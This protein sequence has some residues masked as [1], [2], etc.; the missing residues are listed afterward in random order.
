MP[1]Q[2]EIIAFNDKFNSLNI[3]NSDS[4]I[5]IITYGLIVDFDGDFPISFESFK[6]AYFSEGINFISRLNGSWLIYIHDKFN[7]VKYV[8]TDQYSDQSIY[9]SHSE[10]GLY[11]SNSIWNVLEKTDGSN[12]HLSELG[13]NQMLNFGQCFKDFTLFKN[14]KKLIAGHFIEID[15]NHEFSTKKYHQFIVHDIEIDKDSILKKLDAL[16]NQ[17]V[18]RQFKID[19]YLGFSRSTCFLSGGMDSRNTVLTAKR[20]GFNIKALSFGSAD[21][22]DLAIASEICKHNGI[23]HQIRHFDFSK[24][25]DSFIA[26]IKSSDGLTS[27]E[28]VLDTFHNGKSIDLNYIGVLHT[29]QIG[30]IIGSRPPIFQRSQNLISEL[31]VSFNNKNEF[32]ETIYEKSFNGDLIGN[33]IS[34]NQTIALSPYLDLDFANFSMGLN[35]NLKLRRKLYLE[36]IINSK[37]EQAS[38]PWSATGLDLYKSY[39]IKHGTGLINMAYRK[40]RKPKRIKPLKNWAEF[41]EEKEFRDSINRTLAKGSELIRSYGQS[42]IITLFIENVNINPIVKELRQL[43]VCSAFMIAIQKTNSDIKP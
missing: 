30:A 38:Y 26:A 29:G 11:I 28:H 15:S 32:I 20:L 18:Q 12:P 1:V 34:R 36:W 42:N 6:R 21:S 16:F 24:P 5:S 37:P 4:E 27:L 43:T 40:I 19:E 3:N 8:A 14:V 9:Y 31:G 35:E 39:R 7:N 17:A 25:N 41:V 23:D 2:I 10:K 13:C 22:H 33:K